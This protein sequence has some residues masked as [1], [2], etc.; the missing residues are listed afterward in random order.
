MA[1]LAIHFRRLG[2]LG[3]VW[4]VLWLATY[5][6]P[7]GIR[8]SPTRNGRSSWTGARS[9]GAAAEVERDR[10]SAAEPKHLGHSAGAVFD[11]SDVVVFGFWL[12]EDLSDARGFSLNK[13]P[14]FA[15]AVC[16]RADRH[17]HRGWLSGIRVRRGVP[18]SA[19][20]LVCAVSCVPVMAGIPAAMVHN[21]AWA[22][23]RICLALWGYA[24]WATMG[25][26]F[27][28]DLFDQRWWQ[29]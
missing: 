21:T 1:R 4:L 13:S 3:R 16:G 28:S 2:L 19:R 24:A 20:K 12:P 10:R 25:L 9:C 18:G 17:L 27:P 14:F 5:Y 8:N 29:R 15:A 11:G 22:I 23:G 6:S 7:A 26:T